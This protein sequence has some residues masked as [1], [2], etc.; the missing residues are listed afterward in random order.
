MRPVFG[1]V[2]GLLRSVARPLNEENSSPRPACP[3][4]VVPGTIAIAPRRGS[5]TSHPAM[6]AVWPPAGAATPSSNP[7]LSSTSIG[8]GASSTARLARSPSIRV[9]TARRT[10]SSY[11]T[12][13]PST[14]TSPSKITVRTA[15]GASSIATSR[16]AVIG[17]ASPTTASTAAE[18]RPPSTSVARIGAAEA[19]MIC[20]QV[21][22]FT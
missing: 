3:G 13:A 18:G 11:S 7:G 19:L 2:N 21:T 5:N 15:H 16:P 20:A 22:F 4:E 9:A 14:R 10:A 6:V 8:T 1:A 17:R 12:R